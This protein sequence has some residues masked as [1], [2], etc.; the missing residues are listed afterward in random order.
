MFTT[1]LNF[2]ERNLSKKRFFK[3]IEILHK[4]KLFIFG[5]IVK[6]ILLIFSTPLIHNLFIPF[7]KNSILN[8]SVD[9][10]SNYIAIGGDINSF[11]YGLIMLLAYLP[12]SSLGQFFDTNILD[13]NL[14]AFGFKFSS[15]IFDYSLL[16]VLFTLLKYQSQRLLI[17]CY[18]LS[19]VVI[20]ITYIHGQLD[21]L[22][23]TL[24]I[25]SILAITYER[26]SLSGFLIVLAISSKL[27][28][29]IALPFI[30]IY[31]NNRNGF[32]K[33]IRDFMFTFSL[34]SFLFI[35]SYFLSN[36]Y[37]LMV[38]QSREFSRLYSVFVLYGQDLKLYVVPIIYFLSLYLIW[39]LKRINQDL[40]VIGTGLGF[41]SIL[42]FL[43]PAPGW[44]I[45][46][47]PFLV[48]YQI[49][50][51]RDLFSITLIY[52]LLIV[53]N[54]IVNDQLIYF[55][56]LRNLSFFESNNINNSYIFF[57]NLLFT[58]QQGYS[59]LLALKIYIYGLTRNNFYYFSNKPLIISVKGNSD[60]FIR[61]FIKGLE[62][63]INPRNFN[64][65]NIS[66][67]ISQIKNSSQNF[68][69]DLLKKDNN[70]FHY[71][72]DYLSRGLNR[73]NKFIEK[74]KKDYLFIY[75]DLDFENIYLNR[76]INLFININIRDEHSKRNFLETESS[77]RFDLNFEYK[78]IN[79]DYRGKPNYSMTIYL[80]LGVL[81]TELLKLLITISSLHVDS[82]VSE[83]KNYVKM[84]IEGNPSSED[85]ALI[86]RNLIED[87]DD[88]PLDKNSFS[89]GYQGIM[90]ILLFARISY[91]L[92][93]KSRELD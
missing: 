90:Q 29:I 13:L 31:I 63:L 68:R 22:P 48:Y 87:I 41:F 21:I 85:I 7:I 8:F 50:S 19:P 4:D 30:L 44:S 61:S 82:D 1:P 11:P 9:P 53:S 3:E 25:S 89:E 38:F 73:L 54:I 32:N 12:L 16:L 86:A 59:F 46:L 17:L 42:I 76:K 88:Y 65:I 6:I 93:T 80:P 5:L 71:Y 18:W 36:G 74:N 62:D 39:R 57:K 66:N 14:M 15:L 28:M 77:D 64:F 75:N 37:L 72:E 43:P 58:G 47:I 56:F 26:F 69:K 79:D 2:S 91:L 33:E 52:S 23:L 51:K 55:P 49:K 10:W 35:G 27:S 83:D 70:I 24:L 81:H 84:R 92:K 60:N 78:I 34:F 67:F 45:W 20:Y 40:F